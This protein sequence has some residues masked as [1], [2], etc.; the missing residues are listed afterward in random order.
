MIAALASLALTLL[1]ALLGGAPGTAR[2]SESLAIDTPTAQPD[3]PTPVQPVPSDTPVAAPTETP[4]AAPT[5]TPLPPTFTPLPDSERQQRATETPAPTAT[6]VA[7][8]AE[9]AT[10]TETPVAAPA[11]TPTP[12]PPAALPRTGESGGPSPS[13]GLLIVAAGLA[14]AA[15]GLALRGRR[16]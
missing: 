2:A 16:A 4:A 6:P 7:A 3:T 10:P 9:T 8:P 5:E 11:E 12:A 15:A 14:L 1:A 13:L